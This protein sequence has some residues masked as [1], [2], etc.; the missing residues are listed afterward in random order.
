MNMKPAVPQ[1]I[2]ADVTALMVSQGYITADGDYDA[3]KWDNIGADT[4][5][6]KGVLGV[7]QK[8]GITVSPVIAKAIDA[9]PEIEAALPFIEKMVGAFK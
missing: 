6:A 1:L 2:S 9:A 7:L 5:F 8:H 3:A 4:D